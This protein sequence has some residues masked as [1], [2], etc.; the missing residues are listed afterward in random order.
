MKK[1][2][3]IIYGRDDLRCATRAFGSITL[4]DI[5]LTQEHIKD[6]RNTPVLLF[7]DSDGR[8]KVLG[9]R[10]GDKG[11]VARGVVF[12]AGEIASRLK[13]LNPQVDSGSQRTNPFLYDDTK[14]WYHELMLAQRPDVL[15]VTE[16]G[17]GITASDRY[18]SVKVG[19]YP[20]HPAFAGRKQIPVGTVAGPYVNPKAAEPT[21][22]ILYFYKEENARA[23]AEG[24][25]G[26]SKDKD[27]KP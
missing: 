2:S 13:E 24:M 18:Y 8:T 27:I 23:F 19:E 17:Y 25:K 5:K 20:Q 21:G 12:T 10:Y 6:S 9:N 3:C 16:D 14:K 4:A 7:V 26:K 1:D 22:D 15:F 11:T